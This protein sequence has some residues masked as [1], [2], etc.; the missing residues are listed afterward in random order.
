MLTLPKNASRRVI[1]VRGKNGSQFLCGR[2]DERTNVFVNDRDHVTGKPVDDPTSGGIKLDSIDS[3]STA[4]R[5]DNGIY[6]RGKNYRTTA[7]VMT[8][9]D[10]RAL[11]E[12]RLR[13]IMRDRVEEIAVCDAPQFYTAAFVE[14]I[15]AWA[16]FRYLKHN[17]WHRAKLLKEL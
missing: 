3:A 8:K 1:L 10:A 15:P 13:V 14:G 12:R 6:C 16:E 7:E 4:N 11:C 9:R 2:Y 5:Y 17:P